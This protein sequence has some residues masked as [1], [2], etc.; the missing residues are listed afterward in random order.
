MQRLTMSSSC[1]SPQVLKFARTFT[2][3]KI[4]MED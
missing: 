3:Y 4:E 2:L 1:Q